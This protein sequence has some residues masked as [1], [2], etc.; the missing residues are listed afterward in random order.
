M[1]LVLAVIGVA[2]VA[3]TAQEFIPIGGGSGRSPLSSHRSSSI[4]SDN[5]GDA[6]EFAEQILAPIDPNFQPANIPGNRPNPI[7]LFPRTQQAGTPH[8][9]P[10]DFTFV[11][12]HSYKEPFRTDQTVTAYPN[13][14]GAARPNVPR[15]LGRENIF[16]DKLADPNSDASKLEAARKMKSMVF[17]GLA[18][19]VEKLHRE[20]EFAPSNLQLKNPWDLWYDRFTEAPAEPRRLYSLTQTKR[21]N[22]VDIPFYAADRGKREAAAA[23]EASTATDETTATTSTT[24]AAAVPDATAATA[25]AAAATTTAAPAST[26]TPDVTVEIKTTTAASVDAATTTVTAT[27]TAASTA[28]KTAAPAASW[29]AAATSAAAAAGT[30]TAQSSMTTV[31]T[32]STST[33]KPVSGNSSKESTVTESVSSTTPTSSGPTIAFRPRH[34]T[35]THKPTTVLA[36]L[37]ALNS[38]VPAR[39]TVDADATT[40]EPTTTLA[41]RRGLFRIDTAV[42]SA[43]NVAALNTTKVPSRSTVF[44]RRPHG[45]GRVPLRRVFN[46]T[47]TTAA[48]AAAAAATETASAAVTSTAAPAATTT[49]S[50]VA[51]AL[52]KTLNKNT[53]TPLA[54]ATTRKPLFRVFQPR[55]PL[56]AQTKLP[57]RT[58]TTVNDAKEDVDTNSVGALRTEVNRLLTTVVQL[59][60]TVISQQQRIAQLENQLRL[61]RSPARRALANKTSRFVAP[62]GRT[63]ER[64]TVDVRKGRAV[65]QNSTNGGLSQVR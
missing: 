51:A 2:A 36:K 63:V 23:T 4:G 48:P 15:T 3:V 16:V 41:T 8:E 17:Y 28:G 50:W 9:A 34:R 33:Q 6:D 61:R 10:V 27:T 47:T 35:S 31:A 53:T 24:A 65:R 45:R 64:T 37:R 7:P 55:R 54:T 21:P 56:A 59:Q 62:N 5:F 57:A 29:T 40:E 60:S 46:A 26:T 12:Q 20:D 42:G 44:P 49:T 58:S 52:L 22:I 43:K 38:R 19:P 32:P 30:T 18:P 1:R 39:T 13:F 14:V 11:H 25:A